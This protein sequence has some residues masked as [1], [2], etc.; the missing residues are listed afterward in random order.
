MALICTNCNA[1]NPKT[2]RF[3]DTCGAKLPKYEEAAASSSKRTEAAKA[4]PAASKRAASPR[5]DVDAEPIAALATGDGGLISGLDSHLLWLLLII[6]FGAFLRLWEL[7]LKPLHHDESIHAW[8]AY[9]LF[10]GDAYKYDPAYHG[11]FRYHITALMYFIFGDSDFTTRIFPAFTGIFLIAFTWQWRNLIGKKGALFTAALIAVSPTFTYVSRFIRDDIFMAAGSMGMVWGLFQWFEKRQNKY[12]YWMVAGLCLS[13][14]SHEGTWIFMGIF[15]TFLFFR[16]LWESAANPVEEEKELSALFSQLRLIDSR[17][18]WAPSWLASCIQALVCIFPPFTVLT[19]ALGG[20]GFIKLRSSWKTWAVMLTIFFVPFTLLYST[21]FTNMDG[22]FQGA[23]DSIAYWLGEQKVGRADQPWQFYIYML[24]LYELA[25]V[26]FAIIGGFRVYFG[27]GKPN[28]F[29]MKLV[30]FL[31]FV[32]A[33][34]ILTQNPKDPVYVILM[35]GLASVGSGM[36][37]FSTFAPEKGNHFK[38]FLIYWAMLGYVMF[39][40]AGERMPWLTLHPLTPLTLLAG[41]YLGEFFDREKPLFGEHWI[42]WSVLWLPIAFFAVLLPR[43]LIQAAVQSPRELSS[44]WNDFI[45]HNRHGAF[46]SSGMA[47]NAW[48][49]GFLTTAPWVLFVILVAATPFML[50]RWPK[51]KN[52]T[53]GTFLGLF[54]AA[55]GCLLHGTTNLIFHGDGADPREQHVYV[56]SSVELVELAAKLDR[57]S[58]AVTGGPYL[59]IACEDLCSWPMS[60]YLRDLTN[61]QIGFG[62]PMTLDKV[63]DFPVCITGY[64]NL[65]VP[66]HDT[67]VA[68]SYKDLYNPYPIRF[69][70]WWAPD[71]AAFTQGSLSDEALKAWNLFMYREPWMPSSPIQNPQ[72]QNYVYPKGDSV[73][74]PYGS[75]DACVWVRKDVDRYFQ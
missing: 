31:P 73:N 13:F 22:W 70:R 23:F 1:E 43:Q 42:A 24:G 50:D 46:A 59:K 15:G 2:N 68:D 20:L 56:Q 55:L 11:P 19:L 49:N 41:M 58:R 5:V 26:V 9:K 29:W 39:T 69:R 75:F 35:A 25:I 48:Q 32:L 4:A 44:W 16:W 7:G 72:F 71:K 36:A 12:I 61:S 14:T 28:Y 74:S 62:P 64:D 6:G 60:W 57:M 38:V 37:A 21:F 66:N 40:I 30:A 54:I 34:F 8:Y 53:R 3:C 45:S 67:L 52:W 47:D 27:S 10:K 65:S 18:E 17:M 51:L 33:I 63:K